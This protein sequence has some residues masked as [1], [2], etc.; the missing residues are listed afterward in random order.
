LTPRIRATTR[1][2][3]GHLN[4]VKLEH[5]IKKNNFVNTSCGVG[6]IPFYIRP[7]R[8]YWKTIYK[9]ITNHPTGSHKELKIDAIIRSIFLNFLCRSHISSGRPTLEMALSVPPTYL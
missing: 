9:N 7:N 2:H 3:G 6:F 5:E 8:S 4:N 1:S